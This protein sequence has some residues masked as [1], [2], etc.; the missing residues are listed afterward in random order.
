VPRRKLRKGRTLPAREP[1]WEPL[2]NFAPDHVIDFTWMYAVEL[3]DGTRLQAYENR[4]TDR[5][6]HLDSA[7]R[8]YALVRKAS[9]KIEE[10]G[11]FE[12]VNP[13]LALELVL[14]K[15]DERA[16]LFRQNVPA[17]F[18]RLE[19]ARSATKHRISRER[20]RNV[21]EHCELIFKGAPPADCPRARDK[22][23]VFLGRDRTGTDLEVIAVESEDGSLLVIHAMKLRPRYR[24]VYAEVRP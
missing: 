24:N 7:G 6:L 12:E 11:E 19:W 16:I 23:W 5:L 4:R 14:G 20:I 18:N 1:E 3:T 17:E 21:L 2:L 13:Q 9:C 8:A 10:P 22:R 15:A